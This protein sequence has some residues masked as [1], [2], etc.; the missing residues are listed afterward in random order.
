MSWSGT[1]LH[2]CARFCNN[3]RLVYK[4]TIGCIAKYLASTSTYVNLPCGNQRFTTHSVV[5]RSDKEKG[6]KCYLDADFTSGWYQADY[7]NAKKYY[8][9]Y[10]ICNNVCGM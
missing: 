9:A 2:Q 10:R 5:Y 1:L 6:I 3:L 7:D 8:V 4:H